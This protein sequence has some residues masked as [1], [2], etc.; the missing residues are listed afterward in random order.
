MLT[1]KDPG[2][3]IPQR[4][5]EYG[6][7]L[8]HFTSL[9]HLRGIHEHGL[10]V[11]DVVTSIERV[12]GRVGVWLTSSSSFLGHG[13]EGAAMDKTAFRLEL[14]VPEDDRLVYWNSWAEENI[15]ADTRRRL[16]VA[17]GQS[18]KTWYIYFG[19]LSPLLIREVVETATGE[20]I[21]DWG[22]RCPPEKSVRGVAYESRFSW[23][24]RLFRDV[25]AVSRAAAVP[26]LVGR[27]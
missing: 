16:V 26:K 1:P 11:G 6:M 17:N 3:T 13:L 2:A 20:A 22:D 27:Q 25:K 12:E 24:N 23:Q 10:T 19:R 14:D 5:E 7:R 8:Y 21:A 18:A 4:L 9:A 15:S